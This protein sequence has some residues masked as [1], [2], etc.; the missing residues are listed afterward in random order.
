M[1]SFV[2]SNVVFSIE[3]L[4][5][6]MFFSWFFFLLLEEHAKVNFCVEFISVVVSVGNSFQLKIVLSWGFCRQKVQIGGKKQAKREKKNKIVSILVLLRTLSILCKCNADRATDR[7]V[8]A[9]CISLVIRS[10][11]RI[12]IWI[13]VLSERAKRCKWEN[14][15]KEKKKKW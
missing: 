1:S 4:S 5:L 2:R 15:E 6:L 14:N 13:N 12:S 7:I 10:R 8:V 3:I 9:F 11:P